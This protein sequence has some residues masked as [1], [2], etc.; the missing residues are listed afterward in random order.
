MY[1]NDRVFGGYTSN[2]KI[3]TPCKDRGSGGYTSSSNTFTP[4][5]DRNFRVTL[6]AYRSLIL[7]LLKSMSLRGIINV[8]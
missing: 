8:K 1:S 6:S 2:S 3:F 7:N 5:N 4:H